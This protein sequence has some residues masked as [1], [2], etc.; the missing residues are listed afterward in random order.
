MNSNFLTKKNV[1]V[2]RKCTKII[3]NSI[4]SDPIYINLQLCY[5]KICF[6]LILRNKLYSFSES[7]AI[8]ISIR[9]NKS[10]QTSKL[11]NWRFFVYTFQTSR[12][13]SERTTERL[14]IS[15]VQNTQFENLSENRISWKKFDNRV[16]IKEM[17]GNIKYVWFFFR[18]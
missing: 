11:A 8:L 17:S 12:R 9:N 6:W 5:I 16:Y 3:D 4:N 1:I 7:K 2:N 18:Y 13:I 14:K 15:S 10:N